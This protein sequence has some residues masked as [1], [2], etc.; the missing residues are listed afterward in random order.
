MRSIPLE[1][2]IIAAQLDASGLAIR[3][4]VFT[5]LDCE[6]SRDVTEWDLTWGACESRWE[7]LPEDRMDMLHEIL[8]HLV[9]GHGA[10]HRMV[11]DAAMDVPEYRQLHSRKRSRRSTY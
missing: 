1:H 3:V 5:R 11:N 10:T 7:E 9:V 8:C 4:K 2:S 6:I